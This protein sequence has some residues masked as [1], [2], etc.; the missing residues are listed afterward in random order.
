MTSHPEGEPWRRL[1]QSLPPQRPMDWRRD[2]AKRQALKAFPGR[3]IRELAAI[4]EHGPGFR[5]DEAKR[6]FPGWLR[7]WARGW[8]AGGWW[9]PQPKYKAGAKQ[10]LARAGRAADAL[11]RALKDLRPEELRA[12][13]GATARVMRDLDRVDDPPYLARLAPAV[14]PFLRRLEAFSRNEKRADWLR[15]VLAELPSRLATGARRAADDA[16][17]PTRFP[18]RSGLAF[19]DLVV[20]WRQATGRKPTYTYDPA[21]D[22]IG[23]AFPGFARPAVHAL[24]PKAGDLN[25]L[26]RK[27]CTDLKRTDR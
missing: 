19:R 18:D 27:A 2:P 15:Q 6:S 16:V 3:K 11:A 17:V 25:G 10:R 12:I 24:W 14:R 5:D 20:L 7:E 22:L 21:E 1:C 26:I 9:V 23:G 4:V 8:I 13:S